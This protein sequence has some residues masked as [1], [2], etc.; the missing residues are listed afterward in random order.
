MRAGRPEPSSTPCW[1]RST[2]GASCRTHSLR[3]CTAAPS[4][5]SISRGT[6]GAGGGR[7]LALR[8]Q[9][10]GVARPELDP[11]REPPLGAHVLGIDA[12]PAPHLLAAHLH[13]VSVRRRDERVR[14]LWIRVDEDPAL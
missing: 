6:R 14:L 2:S 8:R 3:G 13:Q 11:L 4:A 1:P 12:E 5:G 10:T 7:G 9:R